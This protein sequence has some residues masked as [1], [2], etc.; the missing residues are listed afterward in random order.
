K[1]EFFGSHVGSSWLSGFLVRDDPIDHTDQVVFLHDHQLLAIELDLVTGPFA[2]KHAVAGRHIERM[3]FA[4]FVANAGSDRD[5]LA[6][7]R[8]FLCR[9]G[10]K[11]AAGGL[12][13]RLDTANQD[14]VLQW[15]Q[16]HRGLPTP[17]FSE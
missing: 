14:A 17:S 7:D 12:R 8:L 2:E 15:T 10:D 3:Q 5:D 6:L 9:I 1:S 16:F 13:F 4:V 11:N